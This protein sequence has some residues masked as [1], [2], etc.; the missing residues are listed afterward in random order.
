[1]SSKVLGLQLPTDPRWVNLAEMRLEDILTD[2][3]YC[4][5]KAATACISLIQ[6]YPNKTYMVEQLTP[7]VAEEWAHFRMVLKEL[8]KRGL[9]LG[10]QRKDEY[11]NQLLK[12]QLKGGSIED[13]FI[14]KLL[15]SALIEARSCERFRLLSENISAE[16]LKP[17]YRNLM[18]AEAMH[19]KLFL[20]IAKKYLDKAEVKKRWK[21]WLEIEKEVLL[22]L[23]IRGDRMH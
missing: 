12:F 11:A 18:V 2:H 9:S 16:E 23:E 14:D 8:E 17:F 15:M 19:Y 13:R 22:Q 6:V 10:F 7:V 21:A 4:E 1:M 20:K 3:A 5:L